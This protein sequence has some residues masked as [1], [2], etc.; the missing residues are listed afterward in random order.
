MLQ[1]TWSAAKSCRNLVISTLRTMIPKM[2][3][4]GKFNDFFKLAKDE[5]VWKSILKQHEEVFLES[6]NNT[7]GT[8]PLI[9][10][11]SSFMSLED[12]EIL[13][14]GPKIQQIG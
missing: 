5:N 7:E 6:I 13:L 3:K 4:Q 10:L 1:E 2:S 8:D 9:E 14:T 12:E 11:D